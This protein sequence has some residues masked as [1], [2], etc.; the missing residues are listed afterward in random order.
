MKRDEK[1]HKVMKKYPDG[2]SFPMLAQKMNMSVRDLFLWLNDNPKTRRHV[3][4]NGYGQ[5][6]SRKSPLFIYEE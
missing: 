6:R 2:I 1:L 4:N 3:K 5:F